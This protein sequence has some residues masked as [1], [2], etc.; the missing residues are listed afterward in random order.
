MTPVDKGLA[1][2]LYQKNAA[3]HLNYLI[4][5]EGLKHAD[6]MACVAAAEAARTGSNVYGADDK[7]AY[8]AEVAAASWEGIEKHSTPVPKLFLGSGIQK[9]LKQVHPDTNLSKAGTRVVSD[10]V[11]WSVDAVLAVVD[12]L[13][14]P[15]S[16]DQFA[17]VHT[18]AFLEDDSTK[19]V[20]A[21]RLIPRDEV[22]IHADAGN[23]SWELRSEVVRVG[24]ADA[25]A[26]FEA[27][28]AAEQEAI[29]K[30]QQD[31]GGGDSLLG[32]DGGVTTHHDVQTAV[33]LLFPA[34]LAKHAVNEGHRAVTKFSCSD[35][36]SFNDGKMDYSGN[37]TA[38]S[39][40]KDVNSA[41]S[42]AAGLQVHTLEIA[43]AMHARLSNPPSLTAAVYLAAAMEYLI[44]EMLELAGNA[45]RDSRSEW[46]LPRF[47]QCAV[48]KDEEF[49]KLFQNVSIL[50]GGVLPDIHHSFLDV[51]FAER[52]G[53]NYFVSGPQLNSF[54]ND[55]ADVAQA[56]AA[57]GLDGG[58]CSIG[59]AWVCASTEDEKELFTTLSKEDQAALLKP[60]RDKAGGSTDN[61][62]GG[63]KGSARRDNLAILGITR[64]M[65]SALA[66][67]AGCLMLSLATFEKTPEIIQDYLK[68]LIRN[69]AT[70]AEYK[71]RNV[72][73]ATDV[74]TAAAA[75][76]G[77]G[78]LKV[79]CGT[80]R[81]ASMYAM[82]ASGSNSVRGTPS[83][84]AKVAAEFSATLARGQN[85]D[86]DYYNYDDD[87]DIKHLEM[88]NKDG[89]DEEVT[90]VWETLYNDE[91][92]Y[93][94]GDDEDDAFPADDYIDCAKHPSGVPF[95][96]KDA[97]HADLDNIR[98]SA[99]KYIRQM[100]RSYGPCI[101]FMRL[102]GLVR[103]IAQ[104]Y[105]TDL[106][107][108]PEA[109]RVIQSMLE[110]Y[111][112]GL[113][114][115]ANL[116]CVH[117]GSEETDCDSKTCRHFCVTPAS[118]QLA[119]HYYY[120]GGANEM[121]TQMADFAADF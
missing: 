6:A 69:V 60:S 91:D 15:P 33:R 44:A 89:F 80:G 61:A 70:L 55:P 104:D 73:Y 102:S 88:C 17:S 75:P 62:A 97:I 14:A 9:V 10:M 52:K 48:R 111:L 54:D 121:A 36:V 95:L 22:L 47:L 1:S 32:Y 117:G 107:F 116:N 16:S 64:E 18:N 59:A 50:D 81:L 34:E 19:K 57:A 76:T 77:N 31:L 29:F 2:V 105:K 101:P 35:S 85:S 53:S 51:D 96:T 68:T 3:L 41:I 119:R 115:D 112:V 21:A 45:A 72:V 40:A 11:A 13:P 103:E 84:F 83:D 93:D 67:R 5:K 26:S 4:E 120:D 24:L 106:D 86:A 118:L 49:L 30:A 63:A 100:Q 99:L 92:F 87:D 78:V 110:E 27:K 66:A 90:K 113:F 20:L 98:D 25:L 94:G 12:G 23:C 109:F 114:H 108:E 58:I 56:A 79:V 71:K 37:L 43:H 28:T 65:I 39:S 8:S 74:L 42:D 82:N 46:I 38:A 7:V